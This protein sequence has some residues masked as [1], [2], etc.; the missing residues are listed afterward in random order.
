MEFSSITIRDRSAGRVVLSARPAADSAR[1]TEVPLVSGA[2]LRGALQDAGWVVDTPETGAV[3]LL[4]GE[5]TVVAR[6]N[7]GFGHMNLTRCTLQ[8][9]TVPALSCGLLR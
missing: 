9:D 8:V 4:S 7:N 5:Y 3:S 1:P 6:G 2:D